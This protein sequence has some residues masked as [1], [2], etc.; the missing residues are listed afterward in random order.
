VDRDES[1]LFHLA[2]MPCHDKKLEA[3]RHDFVRQQ[4]KDVDVVITTLELVKLLHELLDDSNNRMTVRDALVAQSTRH[5][6]W[7]C[8]HNEDDLDQVPKLINDAPVLWTLSEQRLEQKQRSKLCVSN[9]PNDPNS[10]QLHQDE[11]FFVAGAGG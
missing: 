8:V 4:K 5:V 3:S 10:S 11:S 9:P 2:V 6:V 1:S 7:H